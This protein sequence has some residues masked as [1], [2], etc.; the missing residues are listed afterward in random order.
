M[1]LFK[2][3]FSKLRG[4]FKYLI[5]L[6]EDDVI[7]AKVVEH[8]LNDNLGHDANI[9]YFPVGELALENLHLKPDLII[10]DYRLNSK[11]VDAADGLVN[12]RKIKKKFPKIEVIVLTGQANNKI[13]IEADKIGIKNFIVKSE[14]ALPKLAEIINNQIVTKKSQQLTLQ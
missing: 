13:A 6:V 4:S 3:I 12:I 9:M 10:M 2:S 11:F 14:E 7:Y 5:F 8:Y 1:E